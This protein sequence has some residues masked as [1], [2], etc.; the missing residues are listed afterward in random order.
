M[1]SKKIKVLKKSYLKN[2]D[3][4]LYASG[5]NVERRFTDKT[6][7]NEEIYDLKLMIKSGV[8]TIILN[9]QGDYKK[10]QQSIYNI[11]LLI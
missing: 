5:M 11:F 6:R 2:S 4:W 9:H 3:F 8:K 7:I 1:F 10:K